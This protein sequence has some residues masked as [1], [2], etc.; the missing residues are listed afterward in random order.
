MQWNVLVEENLSNTYILRNYKKE[1]PP[2]PEEPDIEPGEG[3]VKISGTVW[4]EEFEGKSNQFNDTKDGGDKGVENVKVYWKSGNK[5]LASTVTDASGYYEM[6]YSIEIGTH[7]YRLNKAD[8]ELINDSYVEFEYNGLKYITVANGDQ[9]AENTSKAIELEDTRK[10]LDGKFNE[11]TPGLVKD[12]DIELTYVQTEDNKSELEQIIDNTA[13]YSDFAVK[14]D[15][16]KVVSDM[17]KEHAEVR[18]NSTFCIEHCYYNGSPITNS[19]W[20]INYKGDPFTGQGIVE[21]V[22]HN[23]NHQFYGGVPH[24]D[25]YHYWTDSDGDTHKSY[26]DSGHWTCGDVFGDAGHCLDSGSEPNEWEI[27]NINLGLVRKEQPDIALTSDINKVR[28]IMKG[29]E[30]TY[31]YNARGLTAPSDELFD[32]KVKFT[33]KYTTEYRR[34]VNPSDIAYIN[35]HNTED[36]LVYVTYDIKVKNQ[37]T[38]TPIEV[39][40]IVNYYDANYTFNSGNWTDTSKYGDTYDSNGYKA[41]YTQQLAGTRLEPGMSSEIIQVEYRVNDDVVK[42]LL[43][44]DEALLK[45]VSEIYIYKSYYGADTMCSEHKTASQRG[46]TGNQYAGIDLDSAPG[47]ATPGEVETYEDDTDMAPTFVLCKDPNYKVISGIV[48]EDTNTREGSNERVGNGVYD[49]GENVVEGALVQLLRIND[50]GETEPA[51][52]YYI[53]GST[54]ERRLAISYTDSGGNY[55]LGADSSEGVVV[56]NYVIKY[57]YGNGETTLVDFDN[58]GGQPYNVTLNTKI[59]GSGG[60]NIIN[61]RNYKS[62]IIVASDLMSVIKGDGGSGEQWHL[63]HID[64]YSVAVDDIEQRKSIPSLTYEN[65]ETPVNMSAYTAPFRVQVEYSTTSQSSTQKPE[66]D[67]NVNGEEFL[68]EGEVKL[69]A[70]SSGGTDYENNW[71]LFDFG[72][73][74]RAREDIVVDKTIENIKITLANGQVLIDGDPYEDKLNYVKALGD[75]AIG[76]N[77]RDDAAKANAKFLF[78]EIDSESI[79]GARL[80]LLYKITVTNNSERDYEYEYDYSN[81]EANSNIV[82]DNKVYYYYFGEITTPLI[83][84]TVEWLVDYVDPEL[85]CTVGPNNIA[86]ED[87][88]GVND[89]TYIYQENRESTGTEKIIWMQVTPEVD[90]SGNRT[91]TAAERL[92]N[93]SH[94]LTLDANLDGTNETPI[95]TYQLLSEAARDKIQEENYSIFITNYFYDVVSETSKSLNLFASKLL[96]NQ[97][98]EYTYENH[99]EILQLNGKIA[100]NID[101]VDD[102]QQVD[103][104]YRMGDYIP[105]LERI[106]T[107]TSWRNYAEGLHELDDDMITVRI[108]PPTGLE[109]NAIIYIS[110]GAVA[111]IV[112]AVGIYIIKKKVLGK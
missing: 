80:D 103:K 81:I 4:E 21:G 47:N 20:L 110:V 31:Y 62:T 87:V 13:D 68:Q 77:A 18:G 3:N 92:F 55:S 99:V 104:W 6:E 12:D 34:P 30:Y 36:L 10:E 94:D 66:S 105:S 111:L 84:S 43:T 58:N 7:V 16:Q 93:S 71:T 70:S 33:G 48:W 8:W 85:T 97:A 5:T 25:H 51:Y 107:V 9:Y 101:S 112:L 41:M 57:T 76:E 22:D 61:A 50:N 59:N 14:A 17:M 37:S 75:S 78:I 53:N 40:E 96:P 79:Q 69:P 86:V 27:P 56:D 100:R 11:V 95:S 24:C 89:N 88:N 67:G 83:K 29:Q 32:Y 63:N 73:I 108:T 91:K 46:W 102:G 2:E 15:T 90:A 98:E 38:T 54:A 65:F 42:S 109:S 60:N 52:L 49:S 19:N 82:K 45:N 39:G 72:I 28:V 74:E 106:Q 26:C 44:T 1:E 23:A 64:N 35:Y